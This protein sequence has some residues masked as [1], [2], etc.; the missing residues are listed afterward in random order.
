[1]DQSKQCH[2]F[3]IILVQVQVVCAIAAFVVRVG[4]KRFLELLPRCIQC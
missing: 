1:M 3:T 2:S 4:L